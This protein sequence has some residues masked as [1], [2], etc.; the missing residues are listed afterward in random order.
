MI[1]NTRKNKKSLIFNRASRV[2]VPK[3]MYDRDGLH[4]TQKH[5]EKFEK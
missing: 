2:I 4:E 3:G 5:I 1:K